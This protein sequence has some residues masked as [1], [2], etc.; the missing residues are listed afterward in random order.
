MVTLHLSNFFFDN[1]GNP[2]TPEG[3]RLTPKFFDMIGYET[4]VN[5]C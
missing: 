2:D 1:P 5:F 4:Q 3:T